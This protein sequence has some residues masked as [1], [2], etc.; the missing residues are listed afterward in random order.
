MSLG[1]VVCWGEL[2]WDRF[3]DETRLGGAPA[4]VACHLAQLGANTT[5]I[6]RLGDDELGR[7]A[8]TRLAAAAID[9]SCVQID[10]QRS[11][12]EVGIVIDASGEPHYTMT[13]G[14]AWEYIECSPAVESA[15]RASRAFCFGT[16]SQ[17][18]PEGFASFQRASTF[19]SEDCLR[20]C[21]P[22]FR[23]HGVVA[24]VLRFALEIADVVKLNHV[25]RNGIIELLGVADPVR[26][27]LYEVGVELVAL[28]HGKD[29]CTLLT[30]DGAV[31]CPSPQVFTSGDRVGAGDAFTAALTVG[32]MTGASLETVG[33]GANRVAGF[34]ASVSGAT[35]VLPVP[36][37]NVF[38]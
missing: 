21:D 8:Q 34:V 38:C 37:R 10:P 16:F 31:P 17:R 28:T 6:T 18:R 5:L 13:P 9:T 12:G 30:R 14:C 15:L 4:N 7:L 19:L 36:L 24:D 33:L 32:L 1:P 25:E 3:P 11:T 26:W 2:L 35:P 20:V 29:G 23:P 27:L 22:N